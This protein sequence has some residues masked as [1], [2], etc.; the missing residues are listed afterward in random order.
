[1]IV[2]LNLLKMFPAIQQQLVY[3]VLQAELAP[4]S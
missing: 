4:Q 1:M 3:T 2:I